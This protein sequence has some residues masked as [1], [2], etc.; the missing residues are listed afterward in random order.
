MLSIQG[1]DP[2]KKIEDEISEFNDSDGIITHNQAMSEFLQ[3]NGLNVKQ[4][5][6][7]FFDYY[8]NENDGS[9]S[10]P[11]HVKHIIL[12]A[13]LQNRSFY[14]RFQEWKI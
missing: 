4:S 5:S 10:R 14:C 1:F 9:D 3:K 12:R 2:G 11:D 7:D 8:S 6:I 13:I